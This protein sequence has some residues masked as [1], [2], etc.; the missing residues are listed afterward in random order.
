M[1]PSLL[2]LIP[3]FLFRLPLALA[4]LL[5]ALPAVAA[6]ESDLLPVDKAFALTASAP[7]RDRIEL[8][9]KIADGYYLYR[10][11]T[12][13][14]AGSGFAS[15]Q[16][17]LPDGARHNDEFFGPVETYRG[18]LLAR[19]VGEPDGP[20]PVQLEVKYRGCADLGICY[21]PQTRRLQVTLPAGAG[22]ATGLPAPAPPAVLPGFGCER[23]NPRPAAARPAG[24]AGGA[25][26]RAGRDRRRR[27]PDPGPAAACARVLHLPG[28]QPFR[29]GGRPRRPCTGAALAAGQPPSRRAFR[30][31][32]RVL[33]AGRGGPAGGTHPS[34]PGPG[35]LVATFQGCQTDGI[36]YPPMT[37]RIPVDLPAGQVDLD[38]VAPATDAAAA[39]DTATVPTT[40]PAPVDA[41][42]NDVPP[43]TPRAAIPCA[44]PHRHR[45]RAQPGSCCWPCSA[46]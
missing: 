29:A 9:W 12:A 6:D 7:S 35:H 4:A 1:L 2:R 13:V 24:T 37:R 5:A 38:S 45:H 3:A 23:R 11:R 15:G 30:R 46:A 22:A 31:G 19:L 33:R 43:L 40:G 10:H 32:R 17:Q 21:P 26:I 36:C 25:G 34:A 14:K 44:V 18:E 27:Q 16:L 8:R 41:T 42:A 20:G 28:P 39:A